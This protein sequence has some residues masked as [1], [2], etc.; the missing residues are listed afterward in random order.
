MTNGLQLA[1]SIQVSAVTLE[2]MNVT[3]LPSDTSGIWWK[4]VEED[5]YGWKILKSTPQKKCVCFWR[6]AGFQLGA[7]KIPNHNREL[8]GCDQH[9]QPWASSRGF[10]AERLALLAQ[11]QFHVFEVEDWCDESSPDWLASISFYC[12]GSMSNSGNTWQVGI[13]TLSSKAIYT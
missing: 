5:I 6:T 2:Q 9:V 1:T 4:D 12:Q 10:T 3:G 7:F 11:I 13:P 8:C